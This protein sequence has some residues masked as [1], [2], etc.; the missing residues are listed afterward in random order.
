MLPIIFAFGTALTTIVG[1]NIGAG[2]YNRAEHAAW[3][4]VASVAILCGVTGGLL[5]LFP[6]SWIP[7]FT[8]DPVAYETAKSYI[9]LVGPAYPFLGMGLILYFASQGAGIMT[10]PIRAMMARFVLSVG[11]ASAL[12][13]YAGYGVEA[14]FAVS[15]VA[16]VIYACII[17]TAIYRGAWRPKA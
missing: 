14:I 1:T 4:G 13:H 2:N 16:L 12:V 11:G 9:Q 8:D 6:Q 15:G 5:A 3:Y 10:W 17:V 7:V